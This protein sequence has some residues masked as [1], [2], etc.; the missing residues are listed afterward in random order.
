MQAAQIGGVVP[1]EM[2]L[3]VVCEPF[4]PS[5]PTFGKVDNPDQRK[6]KEQEKSMR[7]FD[8]CIHMQ[9]SGV[10]NP[11]AHPPGSTRDRAALSRHHP[12]NCFTPRQLPTPRKLAHLATAE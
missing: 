2:K 1:R 11:A 5:N 6:T 7:V 8:V 9:F 12:G 3:G 4:V 10:T